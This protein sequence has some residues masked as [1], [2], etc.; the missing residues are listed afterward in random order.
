ML[1]RLLRS[2]LAPYRRLLGLIVVLQTVQTSA[3]L[4]LPSINARIIDNGV[5]RGDS[6][7]IYTWGAVMLL[8]SL[9]QV[10]FAVAAVYFG[11]KVAM[12]F[13]RDLRKNLFH[14]VTDFSATRRS[15]RSARPP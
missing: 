10:V 6:G 13:G 1:T 2:H 7:Y 14:Q 11:G 9:V 12:S 15:A 5:L 4:I 3:A 8:F